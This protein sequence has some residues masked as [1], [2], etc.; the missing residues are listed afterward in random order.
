[1]LELLAPYAG[2][3]HRAASLLVAGGLARR[4]A[5]PACPSATTGGSDWRG[6][7]GTLSVAGVGATAQAGRGRGGAWL[8]G[9]AQPDASS[10]RYRSAASSL[11]VTGRAWCRWEAVGW[12]LVA[13]A[14]QGPDQRSRLGLVEVPALS[15]FRRGDADG[16]AA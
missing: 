3:R 14:G 1:M 11:G 2:H 4:A 13:A 12:D 7:T 15:L 5:A 9:G 10:L 8:V 6:S 16:E